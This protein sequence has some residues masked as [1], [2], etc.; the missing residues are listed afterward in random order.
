MVHTANVS[1]WS[2]YNSP[3][4]SNQPPGCVIEK[5]QNSYKYCSNSH[6]E[7]CS[8]TSIVDSNAPV[9]LGL[10]RPKRRE[11]REPLCQSFVCYLF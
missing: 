4:N 3:H 2:G 11:R 8:E 6:Q 10:G 1:P 7:I 5:M 9:L